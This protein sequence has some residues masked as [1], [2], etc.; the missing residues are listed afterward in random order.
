MA[1]DEI[2]NKGGI[3]ITETDVRFN[4]VRVKVEQVVG[5]VDVLDQE[6]RVSTRIVWVSLLVGPLLGYLMG[7]IEGVFLFLL[8]IAAARIYRHFRR[9][10][11]VVRTQDGA[12]LVLKDWRGERMGRK[13][14]DSNSYNWGLVKEVQQALMEAKR[15]SGL[16]Q[17]AVSRGG[18]IEGYGDEVRELSTRVR[19]LVRS[20]AAEDEID[21][22]VFDLREAMFNGLPEAGGEDVEKSLEAFRIRKEALEKFNASVQYWQQSERRSSI[23][24]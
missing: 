1:A 23:P 19:R 15:R 3:V 20:G 8:I 21:S 22:A 9:K 18:V 6:E 24:G 11:I 16:K 4:G 10:E 14:Q 2:L 13:K 7:G 12:L 17:C 5:G